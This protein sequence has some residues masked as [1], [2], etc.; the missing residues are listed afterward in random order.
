MKDSDFPAKGSKGQSHEKG[1]KPVHGCHCTHC[2][3]KRSR[4]I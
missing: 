1:N 4:F 3:K 2:A